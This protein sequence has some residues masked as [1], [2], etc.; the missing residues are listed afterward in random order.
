VIDID[1]LNRRQHRAD[2]LAGL[3]QPPR[4]F[5]GD[6]RDELRLQLERIGGGGPGGGDVDLRSGDLARLRPRAGERLEILRLG[7]LGGARAA[8]S[9]GVRLVAALRRVVGGNAGSRPCRPIL[10]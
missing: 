1:H 7:R 10:R 8:V 3:D 2:Q 5:P 6:R 4:D 9:G